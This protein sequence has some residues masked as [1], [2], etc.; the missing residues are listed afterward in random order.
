MSGTLPEI[1]RTDTDFQRLSGKATPTSN[2]FVGLWAGRVAVNKDPKKLSRIKVRI[3]EIWGTEDEVP[4]NMLPWATPCFSF[5]GTWVPPKDSMVWVEFKHGMVESPVWL[6]WFPHDCPDGT[7]KVWPEELDE[8]TNHVFRTP[9]HLVLE[10]DDTAT[11]AHGIE[12]R[13][14]KKDST[15]VVVSE[16][17]VAGVDVLRFQLDTHTRIVMVGSSVLHPFGYIHLKHSLGPMILIT[18]LG[19]FIKKLIAPDGI[20][21]FARWWTRK[22][23]P[24]I[25]EPIS[26]R[27]FLSHSE[28]CPGPPPRM[29][30]ITGADSQGNPIIG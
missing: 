25:V 19:V 29:V 24:P 13:I 26:D 8:P 2:R 1:P 14:K 21:G 5:E 12:I 22:I 4:D 7:P 18:A 10:L 28:P 15:V 16:R 30:K 23:L 11:A 3:F 27:I 20:V 17:D 6:G 9:K